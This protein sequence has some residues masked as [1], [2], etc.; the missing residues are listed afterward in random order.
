MQE[1]T[2]LLQ[3]SIVRYK[4]PKNT[5]LRKRSLNANNRPQ[6]R[7][8]PIAQPQRVFNYMAC[9]NSFYKNQLKEN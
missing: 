3:H 5:L 2:Q 9:L 4:N 6:Y 1:N 8:F 7:A